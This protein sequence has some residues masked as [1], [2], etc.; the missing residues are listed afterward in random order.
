DRRS[1]MKGSSNGHRLATGL[2]G[3]ICCHA[4]RIHRV[5]LTQEITKYA[6]LS[7]APMALYDALIVGAGHN[8]LTTAAYLAK[9]GKKVLVLERRPMVGGITVT[10]EIFP[11]F[12]YS[13][14]AHLAGSFSSEIV[15]DLDLKKHGFELLPL[16][17]LLF[18]PG[19]NGNPL[20]ISR[21]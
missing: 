8:G 19:R 13:P 20:I 21:D 12:K 17:P 2:A 9:A 1:G 6:P 5:D 3:R 15:A 7:K 14:C 4:K 18:A 10:E 11:G 16:D